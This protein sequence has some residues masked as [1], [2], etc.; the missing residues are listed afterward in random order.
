MSPEDCPKFNKC[1]VNICPLDPDWHLRVHLQG[2]SICFYLREYVKVGGK[3]RIEG[4][5][6]EEML[7]QIELRLPEIKS[8]YVDISV[9]LDRAEQSGSKIDSMNKHREAV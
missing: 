2:E 9:R 3:A 6:P 8:R 5:V 4:Y 1:S 7:K